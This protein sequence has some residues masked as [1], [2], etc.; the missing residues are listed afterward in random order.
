MTRPAA[1]RGAAVLAVGIAIGLAA[2]PSRAT[3]RRVL[4]VADRSWW[5]FSRELW[6]A[7]EQEADA[8]PEKVDDTA[9]GLAVLT[10]LDRAAALREEN[11]DRV[12]GEW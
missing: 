5:W 2:R 10:A 6:I 12:A 9:L 11:G 1:M 7:L 8:G 4:G 3:V